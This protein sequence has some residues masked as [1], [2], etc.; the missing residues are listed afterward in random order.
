MSWVFLHLMMNDVRLTIYVNTFYKV[1]WSD[2]SH[3]SCNHD[4][5][6]SSHVLLLCF[7]AIIHRPR[8]RFVIELVNRGTDSTICVTEQVHAR[9]LVRLT[10][11][12][13]AT[14]Y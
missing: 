1:D 14:S 8:D 6:S 3:I 4:L 11:G 5:Q 9:A 2:H 12:I 10:Y 13:L 7:T